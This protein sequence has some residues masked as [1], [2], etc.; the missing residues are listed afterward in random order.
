MSGIDKQF[1]YYIHPVAISLFLVMITVLARRSLRL[2]SFISKGIIRVICC[3][4]LLSYTSL[5]TTSLLLMRPLIFH[6][7]DKVY[8]Y[9]SPDVEYFHGRHL[10]YAI[11]AILF[12]IVIV[13]GL[14]LLL[15]FEPFLN[16]RI[17]FI[18]V[19][20]LLDQ[21]Q[22]CYKD[23]YRCFA[24]YY[25]I[26]RLVIVTIVLINS[27][28]DLFFQFLLITIC[29]VIAILH[30]LFRPYSRTLLNKFDGFILQFL[31]LVS[32]PPLATFQDKFDS[33]LVMVMMFV[34][35]AL[36]L[37]VFITISLMLNKERFEKLL[38]YCYVKYLQL[39]QHNEIPPN[40]I[41]LIVNEGSLEF[42]NII[43]DSKRINATICDV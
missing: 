5:A 15:A 10:V 30:Q 43:D 21:F 7:V 38:T 35:V 31:A 13:I 20:P 6:D 37:L 25:M 1:I 9:V 32:A 11:V 4:L 24:A 29:I 34:L 41:P 16:S 17:N 18:K 33:S 39:W 14:P 42:Y 28:N 12:T 26:C 19:K 8:T 22:G 2:L 27:F 40:E 23:K 3:L 36:P